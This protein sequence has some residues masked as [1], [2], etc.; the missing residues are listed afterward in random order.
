MSLQSIAESQSIPANRA[1]EVASNLAAV[2]RAIAE[3]AAACGR[4]PAGVELIAVSKTH[5]PAL[6]RAAAA[7]GQRAFG[8]NYP[9]EAAAKQDALADLELDWHYIGAIQSNKTRLLAARFGWVHT[10]SRAKIARRLSEQLPAGRSI[11]VCL[12][13]NVDRDPNKAG[14]D[15]DAVTGLLEEVRALPGLQLRGLMTILHPSSEPLAGYRRLAELFEAL[16]PL[17]PAG[18]NTLSMGMSGDFREAIAA[19]ATHVR[20]GS[21]IFGPRAAGSG[22]GHGSSARRTH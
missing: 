22:A 15:P 20:I 7:A 2:R 6:V 16:R 8:E 14:V 19:G 21:A 11:N 12:Q 4:D 18:W 1:A 9:A 17:A 10:I 5:P 3:A 13:V